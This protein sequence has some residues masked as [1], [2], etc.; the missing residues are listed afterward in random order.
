[1]MKYVKMEDLQQILDTI[2]GTTKMAIKG[3][4]TEDGYLLDDKF[5]VYIDTD[6]VHNPSTAKEIVKQ[7]QKNL[8]ALLGESVNVLHINKRFN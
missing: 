4:L 7:F 5:T 8:E 2:Q 6:W 3:S 1:M